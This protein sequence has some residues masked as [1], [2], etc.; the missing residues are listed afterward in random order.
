MPFGTGRV[1][2][3][4]ASS[5]SRWESLLLSLPGHAIESFLD[6][7]DAL[8]LALVSKLLRTNR[9]LPR[10]RP[11]VNG[12][13]FPLAEA[14]GWTA[15]KVHA[16]LSRGYYASRG[17][18]KPNQRHGR[19]TL[20]QLT[21]LLDQILLVSSG[22]RTS[23]LI[24]HCL[25]EPGL[26]A[27]LLETLD[28]L[29]VLS[30]HDDVSALFFGG[31]VFFVSIP[32]FIQDKALDLASD[33]REL[34]LINASASQA[35]PTLAPTMY[36]A[37]SSNDDINLEIHRAMDP[38]KDTVLALCNEFLGAHCEQPPRRVVEWA[39]HSQLSR[40]AIAGLILCYPAVYD[41]SDSSEP[42]DADGSSSGWVV[43]ENCLAMCPLAVVQTSLRCIPILWFPLES[44]ALVLAN[45]SV[46]CPSCVTVCSRRSS[47]YKS[48][49]C[50][51][52]CSSSSGP[53][54]LRSRGAHRRY[55][56]CSR[57]R[58][59][60]AWSARCWPAAS[61]SRRT[62]CASS[63]TSTSGRCRAWPYNVNADAEF[64]QIDAHAQLT[65]TN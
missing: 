19:L 33:F 41:V 57:P 50:R 54:G 23:C 49:P 18:R 1:K 53:R 22:I 44:A 46:P 59:D 14:R 61:T 31:N 5:T 34:L 62:R 3:D 20:A 39:P 13:A 2:M 42:H 47:R 4:G 29:D 9:L 48:S 16:V 10:Q 55:C 11:S 40:T 7:K 30:P 26:V 21:V 25:L 60:G 8:Q 58:V 65:V 17:R 37:N 24:D 45:T 6:A 28:R 51:S 12:H 27:F 15:A 56:P 36:R 63:S 38:V 52:T 32:L 64:G 43:Q 35:T